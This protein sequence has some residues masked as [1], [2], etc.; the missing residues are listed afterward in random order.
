LRQ[1][2]RNPVFLAGCALILAGIICLYLSDAVVTGWW[3]G[4][5]D[6]FGV[7]FIVG[8][9]VDVLALSGLDQAQRRRENT[10]EARLILNYM[11]PTDETAVSAAN[12]LLNHAD[13]AIDPWYRDE[14]IQLI[15]RYNR[16]KYGT[17]AT[18]FDD[19]L[20]SGGTPG[21][22]DA[23]QASGNP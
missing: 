10:I 23:P 21:P 12:A 7:G 1:L 20:P 6:A 4:T 11:D 15:E 8:G 19:P 2:T 18:P 5:L 22:G 3:K 14:L 17:R 16:E 9:V 13:R